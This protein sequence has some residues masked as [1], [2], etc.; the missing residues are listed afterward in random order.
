MIPSRPAVEIVAREG[1][2]VLWLRG[3][4]GIGEASALRAAATRFARPSPAAKQ[5]ITATQSGAPGPSAAAK[6]CPAVDISEVESLDASVVQILAAL[7]A[8]FARQ[9][10]RLEMRGSPEAVRRQWESAGWSGFAA[11]SLPAP[12]AAAPPDAEPP[13]ASPASAPDASQN[14]YG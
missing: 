1:A 2:R 14:P 10:R 8:D 11:E 5:S 4:L 13:A 9:G 6:Q 12:R 3:P 7:D